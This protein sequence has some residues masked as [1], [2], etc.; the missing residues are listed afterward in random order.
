MTSNSS[1]DFHNRR[2]FSPSAVPPPLHTK[3]S[4]SPQS[5]P[6]AQSAWRPPRKSSLS[7]QNQPEFTNDNDDY[8]DSETQRRDTRSRERPENDS[9]KPLPFVRPADIYRRMQEEKQ[10]ERQSQESSRPSMDA[11]TDDNAAGDDRQGNAGG[12]TDP[13]HNIDPRR[14]S[15]P[16]LDPVAERKSEY[17]MAGSVQHGADHNDE[18][19]KQKPT[20]IDTPKPAEPRKFQDSLSPQL[21]DVARMS[22]FGELFADTTHPNTDSLNPSTADRSGSSQIDSHQ[23]LENQ[24]ESTLQHQPSLGFRSVVHQA[25]DT[26]NEQIPETPSSNANSSIG[27]SGSGG[28]SIVSPIISR[29]PSS[30]TK[31][32]SFRDPQIRAATPPTIDEKLE[33]EDR[34]R[35]SG[36]LGT[37]KA[38]LRKASPDI[39]NQRPASFRPGH[40]RDLST[41]S[42]DNS[43]ARTPAVEANRQLQQP[44]EAEL[45]MTTPIETRFPHAHQQ[46]DSPQSSRASPI[47]LAGNTKFPSSNFTRPENEPSVSPQPLSGETPKSPAESTRSRVRNLADK[48]ESGRSSPAGSE[49]AASPVKTSF[50]PNQITNQ[51]RPLAADRLESF[52]PKL[53]GGWES[54]ASLAP[55]PASNYP[56]PSSEP[57]PLEQRLQDTATQSNKPTAA[58]PVYISKEP[59]RSHEGGS[60]SPKNGSEAPASDPFA[61]LAAAGSALAGAFSSAMG[62]EKDAT[63]KSP[64]KESHSPADPPS[65]PTVAEEDPRMTRPRNTSVNTAFIPEASKSVML[66]TPDDEA[67]SIMPTPLDKLSQPVQSGQSKAGDYFAGSTTP[68]QQA[69]G[70]SYTTQ[71]SA[72]IRRLQLLPSLST[73]TGP[74]YESDRLRREIIRELSPRLTGAPNAAGSDPQVQGH[75]R[76]SANPTLDAQQ[77]ESLVIPREYDS[78]WNDSSSERSSRASSVRG[79]SKAVRDAMSQYAQGP[80]VMSPAAGTMNQSPTTGSETGLTPDNFAERPARMPHRFSWEGPNEAISKRQEALPS[81]RQLSDN[82]IRDDLHP[83]P[84]ERTSVDNKP[85]SNQQAQHAPNLV[86]ESHDA[87]TPLDPLSDRHTMHTQTKEHS[88][89]D[90]IGPDPGALQ[91]SPTADQTAQDVP[92]SSTPSNL[93]LLDA[94]GEPHGNLGP[95]SAQEHSNSPSQSVGTTNDLVSLPGPSIAHPKIQSF[96]EILALKDPQ[97]RIRRYNHTREQFANADTGLSHW[98][99]VTAKEFP[100]HSDVLSN[101]RFSGPVNHKAS[102]TRTRLG[103]IIPGSSSGQQP[104]YQQYLNASSP[105]GAALDTSSATG[106]NSPQAY[107]PSSSGGKLSSQQMQARGKDLLHSAGVFGGKANVAAKGLFSKGKSRFRGGNTDKVDK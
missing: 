38:I 7:Q 68:K 1:V 9:N 6:T 101:G 51:A 11:L 32:P 100:E 99:A 94:G 29:G 46:P 47:K 14:R 66:P 30:A 65:E 74:Q 36:S 61:S 105:V 52:R 64:S 26:T 31:I 24:S 67:S 73:D 35:S 4:P 3:G 50:F 13:G 8:N 72:S 22:G 104:Y 89:E 79:P 10:R 60:I 23:P 16:I 40:R 41:P 85:G 55:L 77:R 98:V 84:R 21:P 25:F 5:M 43:P 107:S 58:S 37:P 80:S 44:Q 2:D 28:T 48:F 18:L 76:Q 102:T 59:E 49:R 88:S 90:A 17:G 63:N 54:S 56:E 19:A 93:P 70:D 62:T 45:A 75:S 27:R 71:E 39:A 57:I 95:Y 69:S 34:P 82:R 91:T 15:K 33:S 78:Y 96:R 12:T 83:D 20:N 106:G 53:P 81:E 97:D 92:S 86:V 103:G 42:P 87:S